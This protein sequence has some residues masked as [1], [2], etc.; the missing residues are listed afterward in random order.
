MAGVWG[1]GRQVKFQNPQDLRQALSTALAVRVVLKQ[2]RYAETFYTKF[3]KSIRLSTRQ[4]DREPAEKH[5]T[6]RATNHLG[7]RRC[8][9]AADMSVTSGSTREVEARTEHRCCECEGR[10]H[11]ARECPTK[12]KRGKTQNA[13]GRK[14]ASGRSNRSRSP[15]EEP[16]HAKE[17]GEKGK[18][19]SGKRVTDETDDISL[20]L[21]APGK[22]VIRP[23]VSV[24]LEQGSPTVSMEIEGKLKCLI[25]DTGSNVSILQPGVSR[26]DVRVTAMRPYGVT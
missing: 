2:E 6:K 20:H 5:S 7:E 24:T 8:K 13:P 26:R 4:D 12:L 21:D 25:T 19:G 16:H 17:K 15:G 9:R 14:N 22:A 23:T 10:G 18:Q 1:N 3:N 11:F